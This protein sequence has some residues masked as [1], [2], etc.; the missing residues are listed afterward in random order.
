LIAAII[1]A[2]GASSR[3]GWPKQTLLL[4]GVPML[5]RV[6]ETFRRSKTGKV[7]VVL[8][9]N[10]REVTRRVKFTQEVVVVNRRFAAGISSSLKLGLE[11]VQD[12]AQAA[13]I[14]LGDQPFVLSSTVDK[15]IDAYEESGARIVVPRFLGTR[16]NPVLFDRSLFP[17][18]E[19]ISGDVGAKSVVQKNEADVLEVEVA[20]KGVLVDIDTPSDLGRESEARRKRTRAR[21]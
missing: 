4:E 2:A 9:A 12:E 16:G 8:G 17:Q 20:D 19:R 7:V 18:I 14:A 1:L 6:L 3:M 11:E 10:A 5:E 15:M 21:A 13:I